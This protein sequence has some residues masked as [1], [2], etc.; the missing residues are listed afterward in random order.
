M[1]TKKQHYMFNFTDPATASFEELFAKNRPKNN[2]LVE[3][4]SKSAELKQEKPDS[5]F[6]Q[7]I[8]EILKLLLLTR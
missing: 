3:L 7:E 8:L 6:V 5:S 2:E 4:L 1:T